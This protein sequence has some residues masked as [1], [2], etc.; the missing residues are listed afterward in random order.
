MPLP[1]MREV[2]QVLRR[3][4]ALHPRHIRLALVGGLAVSARTL[5]G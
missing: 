4:I 2:E 3:F 1:L 5:R